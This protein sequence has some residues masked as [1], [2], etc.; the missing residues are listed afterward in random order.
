MKSLTKAPGKN[1]V[2]K[3]PSTKREQSAPKY[4]N[5]ITWE[6]SISNKTYVVATPVKQDMI[7]THIVS[8]Y[9]RALLRERRTPQSTMQQDRYRDGLPIQFRSILEGICMRIYPTYKE[10]RIE[11]NCVP[12]R[13]K[14][15]SKPRRRAALNIYWVELQVTAKVNIGRAY[16]T[17]F[18]S[19][20]D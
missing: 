20:S 6:S 18:L 19:I 9:I 15:S 13:P 1:A 16:A 17:L 5:K 12:E 11:E 4:L 7:Y 3:N 8:A 2:S 14:S 10:E